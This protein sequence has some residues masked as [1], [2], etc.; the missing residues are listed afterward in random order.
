MVK[1]GT[2]RCSSS[3]SSSTSSL[4]SQSEDGLSPS[5]LICRAFCPRLFNYP[6]HGSRTNRS[7]EYSGRCDKESQRTS[8][9]TFC[10]IA[11]SHQQSSPS[12]TPMFPSSFFKAQRSVGNTST[13][14]PSRKGPRVPG[15]TAISPS[16]F[17]KRRPGDGDTS[18]Y[19]PSRNRPRAPSRILR[20]PSIFSKRRPGDGENSTNK[21]SRNWQR[22]QS[23]NTR[24]PSSSPRGRPK[25]DS[26][27]D[28]QLLGLT[29]PWR[30]ISSFSGNR[31]AQYPSS[32]SSI[33][34]SKEGNVE[35][36]PGK[37]D[38]LSISGHGVEFYP[39]PLCPVSPSYPPFPPCYSFPPCTGHFD[40]CE[41]RYDSCP[42][43]CD[44]SDASDDCYASVY[45]C[46][47]YCYEY[48][49]HKAPYS[50]KNDDDEEE[51]EKDH[52]VQVN[53]SKMN[54]LALDKDV[55]QSTKTFVCNTGCV[56]PACD[57]GH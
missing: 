5:T 17:P 6:R 16:L 24:Y 46:P 7:A 13:Y 19:K 56:R 32:S 48:S 35:K 44:A 27:D 18:T 40:G 11:A 51:M 30:L 53:N 36:R 22:S 9:Y 52:E 39:C 12:R 42:D 1:L 25:D 28:D 14:K 2:Y 34:Y 3:T 49:Y 41:D 43:F 23:R 55:F 8:Q 38:P 33:R 54:I 50:S 20:L 47:D 15:C 37:P 21:P 45:D 31:T 26:D 10:N 29:R 57:S 4:S